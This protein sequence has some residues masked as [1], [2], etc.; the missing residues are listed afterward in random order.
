[1]VPAVGEVKRKNTNKLADYVIHTHSKSFLEEVDRST[2]KS[3]NVEEID[4]LE[5]D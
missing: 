5:K 2:K 3:E 4:K 1:M